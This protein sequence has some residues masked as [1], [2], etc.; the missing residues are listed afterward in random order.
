MTWKVFATMTAII[1]TA[2]GLAPVS[3]QPPRVVQIPDE[4]LDAALVPLDSHTT[5][6]DG[7][8][9][10][11]D[12]SCLTKEVCDPYAPWTLL[13]ELAGGVT[14]TGWLD[15]GSAASADR[16]ASRSLSPLTFND[17]QNVTVNQAYAVIERAIDTSNGW[18][19]GG[20][21]DVLF[22]SDAR[23][24][25]VP[26]LELER[27]GSASKWNS[28]TYYR[29][30]MPQAYAEIGGGKWSAKVGHWYT[31]IGY[32]RVTALQNFFYS[33]A[34]TMAYGEPFTHTGVLLNYA[35]SDSVSAHAAVHSGWNSFDGNRERLGFLGGVK[36]TSVDAQTDLAFTATTGDQINNLNAYSN[37][38]LYSIVLTQR[39][40]DDLTYIFQHDN[41]WQND[42]R[43]QGVDSEWYGINQYLL[44]TLNDCWSMGARL[45]WFRDDDGVR[46]PNWAGNT[47]AAGSYWE[48]TLGMN[49][50]PGTN[51]TLRPEIR[52]DWFNGIGTPYADGQSNDQFTASFDAILTF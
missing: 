9:G 3:A 42:D 8:Y 24:T 18:D 20:R 49:W 38:S 27:D 28:H 46:V 14:I 30:S 39:L 10:E 6:C 50:T 35:V 25:E 15:A 51:L 1:M 41:A 26:G 52:W 40:N 11:C 21:I 13:P 48:A 19:V 22:G 17:R 5:R 12:G 23:F 36:W 7:A 45:E 33:H 34:Y 31:T 29:L 2:Y 32:E 43:G 37:R 4:A 44:Y 47:G 16:N